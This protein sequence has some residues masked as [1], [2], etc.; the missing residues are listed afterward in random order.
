[1]S[2]PHFF[3]DQTINGAIG[4]SLDIAVPKSVGE[5]LHALRLKLGEHIILVDA[6]G[7]GLELELIA[8]FDKKSRVLTAK[9]V[10]EV[11]Y[12][13]KTDLTL[14]QGISAADRMDQTIRQVT[15]LGISRIVPLESE[16]STVRLDD[17]SKKT[18]LERW[19]RVAQGA[20]EQSGQLFVPD[21]LQP[22]TL[23]QVLAAKDS[24]DLMLLF[25]EEPGGCSITEAFARH[26]ALVGNGSKP[27]RHHGTE[28]PLAPPAPKTT[29]FIGPEGGFSPAEAA[30]ITQAG[31]LTV[32]MGDTI[33]RTETA[34]VVASALVLYQL[35]G[36]G[37][38]RDDS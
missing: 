6:P 27:F 14:V 11:S 3:I 9:I 36:L 33:L 21:V 35:G 2:I 5:H 8:P 30:L 32:T 25:W 38:A 24:Y 13:R 12:E 10:D 18:K 26:K 1:M 15:E 28:T 7:H 20:A 19:K 22:S 16:R 29:I 17:R 37:A 34:A 23:E 31:A 4:A